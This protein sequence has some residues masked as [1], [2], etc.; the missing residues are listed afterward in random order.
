MPPRYTEQAD[1]IAVSPVRLCILAFS[2]VFTCSCY[3][4]CI[5]T[6]FHLKLPLQSLRSEEVEKGLRLFTNI[7]HVM[8]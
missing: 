1:Q 5:R 2:L 4:L 7:K 3:V 8:L 6:R